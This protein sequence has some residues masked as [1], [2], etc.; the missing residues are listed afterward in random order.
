[1][2]QLSIRIVLKLFLLNKIFLRVFSGFANDSDYKKHANRLN[3]IIEASGKTFNYKKGCVLCLSYD[4]PTK[5][6]NRRNEVIFM[7]I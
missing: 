2:Y 6:I 4:I 3:D 1:M 5:L 7:R